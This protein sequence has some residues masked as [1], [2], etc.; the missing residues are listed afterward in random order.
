MAYRFKSGESVGEGVKR[1]LREELESAADLLQNATNANRDTAVH[2]ARKSLKKTRALLRLMRPE[3][4]NVYAVENPRLRDIG[5]KLSE[6]RD[7]AV[8][9]EMFDGVKQKYQAELDGHTLGSIRRGLVGQKRKQERGTQMSATLKRLA[10]KLRPAANSL[11]KWS[12]ETDG[13]PAIEPGLTDSY[14][15]ARKAMAGVR[16]HSR[17]EY[18]HEWRKRVKDHWYDV[19]LLEDLWTDVMEGYEKSLKDL[20][21]WLGDHHNLTVLR[22]RLKA[23]PDLYG[24]QDD[25]DFCLKLIRKYQKELRKNALSLGERVYEESPRQFA[26]RMKH[27]WN[28]WQSEPKSLR[29][30]EKEK[31]KASA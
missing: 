16:D 13:F 30:I 6:F 10:A 5:R 14:R 4:D 27:L 11:E 2:E 18:A 1:I 24:N 8:M 9:V 28:S 26:T 31:R 29:I 21:T 19:R 25:I 3:L 23:E 22:D 20:E 17:P 7:T 12:P 15:S